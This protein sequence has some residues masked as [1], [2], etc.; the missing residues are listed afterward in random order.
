[1]EKFEPETNHKIFPTSKQKP[2]LIEIKNVKT[3]S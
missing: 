2:Q 1:M 3:F